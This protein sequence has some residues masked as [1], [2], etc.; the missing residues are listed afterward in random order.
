MSPG[1]AD[2]LRE[3]AAT[4]HF[5]LRPLATE[6]CPANPRAIHCSAHG[7]LS[8]CRDTAACITDL[9]LCQLGARGLCS[10][11][12]FCAGAL[13]RLKPRAVVASHKR[14]ERAHRRTI[15]EETWQYIRDFDRLTES[16]KH[17]PDLYDRMLE[18][19]PNRVNLGWAL[20]SSAP[21]VKSSNV[22]TE[23]V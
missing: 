7:R 5:G 23:A 16:T 21:A 9:W 2:L 22:P 13:L 10:T 11:L 19:Y 3:G 6:F 17:A 1:L 4:V 14:P 15:I 8:R 12:Q 20:W 18:L